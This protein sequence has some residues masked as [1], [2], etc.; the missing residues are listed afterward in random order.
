MCKRHT[1]L[2]ETPLNL[3]VFGIGAGVDGLPLKNLPVMP[4]TS[5]AEA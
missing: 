4:C 5:G 3:L 1:H 2:P